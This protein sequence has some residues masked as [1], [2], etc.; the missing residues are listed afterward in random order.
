M[1]FL[2]GNNKHLLQN[3]T[4]RLPLK[5]QLLTWHFKYCIYEYFSYK[6]F[7][8]RISFV[9][10]LILPEFFHALKLQNVLQLWKM[11]MDHLLKKQ[12][13]KEANLNGD[14]KP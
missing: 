12:N 13:I 14:N 5:K 2:N 9:P 7:D 6:Y 1:G 3:Y 4:I 10:L 8:F 11:N